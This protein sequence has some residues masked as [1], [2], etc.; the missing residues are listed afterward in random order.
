MAKRMLSKSL[1]IGFFFFPM[2]H[3]VNH[4]SLQSNLDFQKRMQSHQNR[5][6]HDTMKFEDTFQQKINQE[7]ESILALELDCN[8]QARFDLH[9][10]CFNPDANT[11]LCTQTAR[12]AFLAIKQKLESNGCAVCI[13]YEP[14]RG[15][16]ELTLYSRPTLKERIYTRLF[17]DI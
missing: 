4:M 5:I 13:I 9:E 7:I 15:V 6:A 17:S 2:Y 12:D 1:N 16:W 8:F 11:P 3:S 14:F 10:Y